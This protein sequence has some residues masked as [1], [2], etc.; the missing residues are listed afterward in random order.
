MKGAKRT[1]LLTQKH[2]VHFDVKGM[3]SSGGAYQETTRVQMRGGTV[4]HQMQMLDCELII[5]Q[6]GMAPITIMITD[7]A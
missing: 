2:N 4:A 3:A 1:K 6:R 5:T 7:L